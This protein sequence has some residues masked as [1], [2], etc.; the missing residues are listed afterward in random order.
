MWLHIHSIITAC[1][2]L[3]QKRHCSAL[4]VC[5]VVKCGPQHV[6]HSGMF[7][8]RNRNGHIMI[9]NAFN[10]LNQSACSTYTVELWD[11]CMSCSQLPMTPLF[12]TD[13]FRD[14]SVYLFFFQPDSSGGFGKRPLHHQT[15]STPS[16]HRSWFKDFLTSG[17]NSDWKDG[18]ASGPG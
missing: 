9:L 14:V 3:I 13:V 11:V 4:P 17:H 18:C 6:A 12:F 10:N 1:L 7:T 16:C 8:F 2:S 15:S 5:C